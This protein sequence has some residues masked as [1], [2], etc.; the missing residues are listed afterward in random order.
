MPEGYVDKYS[1]DKGFGYIIEDS[2]KEVLVKRS[3]LDIPGYKTLTPGERVRFEMEETV[4]GPE[5]KKVR[6][7]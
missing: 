5:A 1:Q 7:I 2:G 6:K 4:R 3:S